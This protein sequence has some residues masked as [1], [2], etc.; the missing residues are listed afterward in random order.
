MISVR[1]ATLADEQVLEYLL[2]RAV[3][4]YLGGSDPTARALLEHP[5]LLTAWEGGRLRSCLGVRLRHLPMARV[6]AVVI[7]YRQDVGRCL[8]AMLP[9]VEERLR[10]RGAGT[11]VYIGQD[12]WL[13]PAFKHQGFRRVNSILLFR[14]QG[15]EVPTSGNQE[16]RIRPATLEDIPTLVDLDAAAFQE[17][18]WRNTASAFQEYLEQMPHFI[19]A[20]QDGR[21][22]GYQ[23][24]RLRGS[25][26]YLARVA[27]HPEAHGQRIG[28]R[29]VAEAVH[30]FQERGVWNIMLNTQKGN[31]R[32]RRLYCWFG[33]RPEGQEVA[34][35]QKE[36]AWDGP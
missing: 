27:V 1:P 13:I 26:G 12:S 28:A 10:E 31:Y 5:L 2:Y 9:P 19:V 7:R 21:V 23:F 22:V 4:L 11:L 20:E 35:L 18:I 14:K 3:C 33:F 32:A 25:E 6:G 17:A 30:F 15:W 8:R 24:S 16:V 36:I 29:L 34:V